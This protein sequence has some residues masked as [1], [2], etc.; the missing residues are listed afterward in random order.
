MP[1]PTGYRRSKATD[2]RS[3]TTEPR[4]PRLRSAIPLSLLL[5]LWACGGD[6]LLLPSSGQAATI[7]ILDGNDQTGTVGQALPESLI[8]LVTD[9]EDRPVANVE[10]AF[11]APAGA[12]LTPNDTVVTGEDGRAAVYYTLP[13]VAGAQTVVASAKP[14]VP[15]TSLTTT[16]SA[17]AQPE[18][19]VELVA[20]GG[21]E[22][23]GD[24][25]LA[26]PESLAVKAVDPFGNGVGGIEVVWS[27]SDGVVSPETVVTGADGRAATQRILGARPGIYRTSATVAGLQGSPVTFEAT[28]I[29][30][31]SPQLV[32]VTEPSTAVAA[33]VPLERQ[34]VL[35]LQDAVGAP[36]ARADVA[37][38]A[39]ISDGGGSLGGTTTVRSDAEGRVSFT[40][41]SIR[42]SPGDRTLLF[43]AAD[44]TPVTS[45]E[46][47]VNP[48]PPAPGRSS[49][50]V[51]NG[52]AGDEVAVAIR[53]E[54]EFGTEIED[55]AEAIRI[56]I[57]GPNADAEVRVT[58]RGDG[59]Y[60][61]IYTPTVAGTDR[62]T[63]EVNGTSVGDSPFDSQV[64]PGPAT[65]STTTA[66]VLKVG[67][68]F[69]QI[70]VVVTTRDIHGNLRG[71]GGERVQIE[72]NGGGGL[73]D[74]R[75]NGDGTYSD[76]FV[77][78]AAGPTLVILL[79]GDPISGSPFTP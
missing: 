36:L 78:I 26:L 79:N 61:G 10:V 65:P 22:Q 37:V 16:F 59:A 68:F 54:D 4:R 69:Y 20:A 53:L 77:T 70:T 56:R 64:R 27:A 48:G 63:V 67:A 47:D 19:A 23:E 66:D 42:G 21:N 28:G 40:D 32:V 76:D 25:Q 31:P 38:S 5:A 52:T 7:T 2:S 1:P 30:P 50:S 71:Q 43:A 14:A 33:G 11:T 49:A 51:P 34:P 75:D 13:T 74:A 45:G 12:A 73:R 17:T 55:A 35:Q 18:A 8:V 9:P 24:T 15:S 44:F 29:A 62:V 58:D 3:R 57:E 72:V 60:S 6:D 46:I 39:Q 41:L